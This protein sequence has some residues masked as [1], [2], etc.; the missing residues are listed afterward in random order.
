[1]Q[2][3]VVGWIW[4]HLPASTEDFIFGF[5]LTP[6]VCTAVAL[7]YIGI[8]FRK[9]SGRLRRAIDEYSAP[10]VVGPRQ[11]VGNVYAG[12]NVNIHQVINEKPADKP[13]GLAGNAAVITLLANL[14]G[15]L[16]R[17]F[18]G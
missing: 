2:L 6:P 11:S 3:P 4:S 10:L 1:M 12:G 15:A 13:L 17:Y 5:L 9:A 18:F 8:R 14:I 16:I 7:A